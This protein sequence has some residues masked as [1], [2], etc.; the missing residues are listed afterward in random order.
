MIR[1][2]AGTLNLAY[3]TIGKVIVGDGYTFIFYSSGAVIMPQRAFESPEAMRAFGEA[4]DKR[5]MEA[6]A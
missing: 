5:S 2:Q 3:E 1:S 6:A 4:V